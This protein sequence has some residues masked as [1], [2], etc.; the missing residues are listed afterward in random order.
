MPMPYQQSEQVYRTS[1]SAREHCAEFEIS[2][3][4]MFGVFKRQI[5][6]DI[7]EIHTDILLFQNEVSKRLDRLRHCVP[8]AI[9][10]TLLYHGN[11]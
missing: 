1:R 7:L 8:V 6:L 4:N 5:I 9:Y 11:Q 2:A 3:N 10:H